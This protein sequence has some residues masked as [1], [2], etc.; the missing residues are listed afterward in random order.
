MRLVLP[1]AVYDDIVDHVLTGYPLEACGLLVGVPEQNGATQALR[2][3]PSANLAVSALAYTIDPKVHLRA[4][5]DAD[6]DDLAVIGVV[7]SHTHTDAF[8]SPTD[9]AAAPDPTWE[10]VIVSLR[11]P[12]P[13]LRSYRI[14]G[15]TVT[16]T[17]VEIVDRSAQAEV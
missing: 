11:D 17:P 8:P 5:R 10:Y 2:F 9:V 1:Q 15:D 4:E 6:D 7:H 13:S 12:S 16:E 3:V 14:Q